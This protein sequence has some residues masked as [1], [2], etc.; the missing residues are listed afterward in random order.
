MNDRIHPV[1][2]VRAQYEGDTIACISRSR[3][4]KNKAIQGLKTHEKEKR[5]NKLIPGCAHFN[6]LITLQLIPGLHPYR[7]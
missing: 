2:W 6:A 4:A 7:S 1:Q 5:I 3:N